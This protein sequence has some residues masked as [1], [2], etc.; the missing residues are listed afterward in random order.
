MLSGLARKFTEGVGHAARAGGWVLSWASPSQ[1]PAYRSSTWAAF[2]ANPGSRTEIQDRCCQGWRASWANH[3]RTVDAE[4]ATWQ[5]AASSRASSG[6]LH[7]DSGRPDSAG[8]AH[9]NATTS[10]RSAAVNTGGR[11]LRRA[12]FSPD[13]RPATRA[14]ETR[15]DTP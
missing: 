10:A 11:P 3:R 12:S 2:T 4:T 7:F 8:N 14:P 6:Q 5:R 13:S 1:I 9:A 15:H